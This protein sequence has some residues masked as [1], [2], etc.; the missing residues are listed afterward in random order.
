MTNLNQDNNSQHKG[1][2]YVYIQNRGKLHYTSTTTYQPSTQLLKEKQ[3]NGQ[4]KKGINRINWS[5]A[6]QN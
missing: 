2:K 4:K 5:L 1:F 6:D 3:L